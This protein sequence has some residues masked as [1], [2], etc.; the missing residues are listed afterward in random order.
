MGRREI[1]LNITVLARER[2]YQCAD[3]RLTDAATG[4]LVTDSSNKVVALRYH[5]G[6]FGFVTYTGVGRWAGKDTSEW[7]VQW[8]AGTHGMDLQ[9]VVDRIGERAGRW[10]NE[11]ARRT[12]K[13]S[14]HTFVVAAFEKGTASV[15]V[16]SNFEEVHGRTVA[17]TQ[18]V[19]ISRQVALNRPLVIVHWMETSG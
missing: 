13:R 14:P 15:H 12:G 8:L 19:H 7:I 4:R 18:D 1:T 11:V 6:F 2:I 16:V 3:L 10:L 17:P 5:T 9:A